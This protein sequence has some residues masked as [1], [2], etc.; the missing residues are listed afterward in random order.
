MTR[1]PAGKSVPP[2]SSTTP[3]PSLPRTNGAFEGGNWPERIVWS[4]G[5][6]PA[7]VTRTSTFPYEAAG[8]GI[9]A[10]FNASYPLNFS[11]LMARILVFFI[12]V[13]DDFGCYPKLACY[14]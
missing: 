2:A 5:V 13:L 9:S 4:S 14:R 6:T 12:L 8:F 11:A 7:A 3:A 1:E 10:G